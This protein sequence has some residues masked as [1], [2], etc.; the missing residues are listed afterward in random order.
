M[1]ILLGFLASEVGIA[2][3]ASVVGYLVRFGWD[4]IKDYKYFKEI[5]TA[6]K[7]VELWAER[8]D[9]RPIDILNEILQIAR[10]EDRDTEDIEDIIKK[11]I[12]ELE[13]NEKKSEE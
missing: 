11:E 8:H 1:E 9:Y 10:N 5:E 7:T 4:K 3:I 12:G 6:I 2:I 13:E